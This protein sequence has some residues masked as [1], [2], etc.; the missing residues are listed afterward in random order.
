MDHAEADLDLELEGHVI[1]APIRL[2]FRHDV[3]LFN[4]TYPWHQSVREGSDP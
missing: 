4:V 3:T 2:A 1:M